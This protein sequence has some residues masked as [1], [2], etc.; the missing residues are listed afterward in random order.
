[1]S[2]GDI[3]YQAVQQLGLIDLPAPSVPAVQ[4]SI[5][6]IGGLAAYLPGTVPATSFSIVNSLGTVGSYTAVGIVNGQAYVVVANNLGFAITADSVELWDAVYNRSVGQHSFPTPI[7]DGGMDSVLYDLSGQTLSNQLEARIVSSTPG[8]TVLSTAD[9]YLT[10]AI[11]FEG[12]LTVGSAT[13]EVPAQNYS[14]SQPVSLGESDVV[15]NATLTSGTLQ[16]DIGN[17]TNLSPNIDITFP[18][19]VLGGVPLTIQRS[20]MPISSGAATIDLTGYELRPT[21]STLPQDIAVQAT[22]AVAGTAP[23]QVVID[24]TD[25]FIINASLSNLAFGS[26]TGVFSAV[27]TTLEPT[28]HEIDVPDGFDSLQLVSAALTLNIEN[29]VELPG[30]FAFPLLGNNGK[31]FVLSGQIAAGTPGG[32]VTTQI[33]DTT[34]ANF[35]SPMP[36]VIT[37]SGDATFGD[38]VSE[39]AIHTGDYIRADVGILAPVEVII[40]RTVVEPDIE[41][42][43]IDQDDID[44][45]TGNV[46]EAKL[47]YNVINHMPLGVTVNLFLGP[48]SATLMSDPEVAFLDEIFVLAAPTV[49]GIASDTLSTGY[50]E[51]TIDSADVHVLEHDTLYIGTQMILEDS[52]GQPVKLTAG[53]YL[54]VIGRVEVEYRFDGDF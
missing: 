37:I 6:M 2:T 46:I 48:D 23:Q 1:L 50:Q 7:A 28:Q 13:A 15:Y 21:D 4:L 25:Q 33:V 43:E 16:I 36:S 34:V 30:G 45:V 39:G 47:I 42:E 31:T 54:T 38:G 9:K 3:S 19:L 17:Q 22:A 20:L 12:D 18:D 29:G 32:P 40:P 10:T 5:D 41:A 49:A 51:V 11:R 24:R 26:V 14:F 52:N 44:A 27:T 35:L 53:D 8:G